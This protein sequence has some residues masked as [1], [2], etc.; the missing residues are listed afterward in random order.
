MLAWL[1]RSG[2]IGTALIWAAGWGAG[3]GG[4]IEA[5]VDPQGE[6]EDVWPMV[7]TILGA[8]GGVAFWGLRRIAERRRSLDGST[9]SRALLWG[10]LAGLVAGLVARAVGAPPDAILLTG[11]LGALSG[12]ATWLLFRYAAGRQA[13]LAS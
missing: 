5:F 10:T 12:P 7:L 4:F 1:I 3:A 6:I 2:P 9:A 13:P 11:L 8:I